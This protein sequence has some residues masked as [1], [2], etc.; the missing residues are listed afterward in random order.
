MTNI[1]GGGCRC[2][3]CLI[4][5]WPSFFLL[6]FTLGCPVTLN[7][8]TVTHLNQAHVF[9]KVHRINADNHFFS[10]NL[11]NISFGN[12]FSQRILLDCVGTKVNDFSEQRQLL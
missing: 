4:F 7:I 9:N 2:Y 6:S 3:D 11:K 12:T 10:Q 1:N 8:F 5:P